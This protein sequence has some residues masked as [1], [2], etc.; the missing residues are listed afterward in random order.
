MAGLPA[1]GRW[2]GSSRACAYYTAGE[3]ESLLAEYAALLDR[4]GHARQDA[5]PGARPVQVRM[6]YSPGDE[7]PEAL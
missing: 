6:F 1:H 2:A 5:P 7:A 3:L 4:Y